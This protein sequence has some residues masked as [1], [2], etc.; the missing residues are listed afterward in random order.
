MQRMQAAAPSNDNLSFNFV[1]DIAPVGAIIRVPQIVV[2]N[3]LVPA[4]TIA[5]FIA[6]SK[7]NPGKINMASGGNGAPE[8][9]AGELFKLVTGATMLHVPYRGAA[10]ALTDLLAGQV[11]VMVAAMPA[12]IEY[13]RAGRLRALAV[14]TRTRAEALPDIPTVGDFV[15]GYEASQWYGLGAPHGTPSEVTDRLNRAINAGLADPKMRA[16]LAEL[17]GVGLPGSPADFGKIIAD[18][19]EKWA[20]VIRAASIKAE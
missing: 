12:S 14:T 10:P 9:M 16:R 3:P 4:K 15:P 11:Q 5:E 18:E 19:N 17:G 8:Q 6:Y 7:A 13:V 20:N 1:R 2:V